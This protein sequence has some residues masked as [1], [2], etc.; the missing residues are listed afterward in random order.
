MPRRSALKLPQE[1]SGSVTARVERM[2]ADYTHRRGKG[3]YENEICNIFHLASLPENV[4]EPIDFNGVLRKERGKILDKLW[5]L[6]IE[7]EPGFGGHIAGWNA[8][9]EAAVKAIGNA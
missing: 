3:L 7:A 4:R 1:A 2:S 6:R 9:I 5:S 8:A